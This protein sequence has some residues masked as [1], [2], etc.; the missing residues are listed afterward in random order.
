MCTKNPEELPNA[1]THL[2]SYGKNLGNCPHCPDFV[3]LSKT[4]KN[5]HLQVFHPKKRSVVRKKSSQSAEKRLKCNHQLCSGAVCGQM[6]GTLYQLRKHR[7]IAKH[8]A[9]RKRISVAA[10]LTPKRINPPSDMSDSE[11]DN[12][13][14][15]NLSD[16]EEAN[17][18]PGDMSDSEEANPPPGDMSDSEEANPPPGDMSDSEGDSPPPSNMSDSEGDSPP[19][20][21]M[22]DFEGDNLPSDTSDV[23][24]AV[25]M[26]PAGH[27]RRAKTVTVLPPSEIKSYVTTATTSDEGAEKCIVYELD[28]NSIAAEFACRNELEKRQNK[29]GCIK[30]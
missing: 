10:S 22:S 29:F 23:E 16:S 13:P 27:S 18:P 8:Q 6:F 7:K 3:F 2:P 17:P 20:S 15:N 30:L 28:L 24:E 4:A 26:L 5:R 12:P 11:G 25:T 21:N 1:D 14:P 9:N 19:P